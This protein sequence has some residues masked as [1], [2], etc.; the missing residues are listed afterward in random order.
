MLSDEILEKVS[1]R[2]VNRIENA[3]TYILK[4]IGKNLDELGKLSYSDA[5]K[6]AQIMKYGGDYDKIVKKLADISDLNEKDIRDIFDEVAQ[7]DY[8]FAKQFYDYKNIKYTPYNQNLELKSQVDAITNIT[9]RE[10]RSMMN[11]SVLG[12][13]MIDGA[14][15]EVT[16]KG[17][18]QAY[19]DLLDEA[20][21]SVGQGKE[22]F[23]EAMSRQINAMGGGG[24]KVVYDSTY[25]DKKGIVRNRTR[26]LD[27]AIRM[28]MKD[29][30]RTLHNE[31]Q[32]IF[33]KQFGADGVE[34]SVHQNPAPDHAVMQGRQ[35]SKEEYNKLQLDG[36]A[37]DYKGKLIDINTTSKKGVTFHRPVSQYN[38][39]HYIFNIVL[40]VSSP[41]YTEEQ[42]QEII[43]ENNKGFEI[44]GKHYTNY[45]GTQLQRRLETQIR[46]AKDT[47][48][49]AKESG[50][51]DTVAESQRRITELTRKYKE[52]SDKS[53]LP[54]KM[55]RLKVEGYKR[56]SVNRTTSIE[57]EETLTLYHGS[58]YDFD[59]FSM[60][61][62]KENNQ[63]VNTEEGHYFTENKDF[64]SD[65]GKYLYEVKIP[66]SKTIR[67]GGFW[68]ADEKEY[69]VSKHDKD[70]K[71]IHKYEVDNS[72]KTTDLGEEIRDRRNKLKK[73]IDLRDEWKKENRQNIDFNL[74]DKDEKNQKETLKELEK[75]YE[76]L[77]KKKYKKI[78]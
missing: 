46:S 28:N 63:W 22:T 14:T 53:G 33:G 71:I 41:E 58:P 68:S 11:P 57:K 16:F 52:L 43:D 17:I 62:S 69:Y 37:K 26:R 66:K 77:E 4:T 64:A 9:Q 44:D 1:E 72:I 78:F 40:G 29:G 30:L 18:K 39:Y 12:Y 47:Q 32:D 48:I 27:S 25:V 8:E 45:E 2:L 13:G 74:M 36:I 65:Y 24:L 21:L 34:V 15:G 42:L 38:C 56:A 60:K 10:I 5:Y 7:S 31:T 55:D 61:K 73:L 6:L 19:Y 51:L 3:N 50:Q 76:E 23:N 35:F 49:M 59:K 54:T 67:A 20:V 70:I 75:Q